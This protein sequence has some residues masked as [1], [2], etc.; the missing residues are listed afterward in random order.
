MRL[1]AGAMV[2]QRSYW[3]CEEKKR[4]PRWDRGTLQF[5]E[6]NTEQSLNQ[7]LITYGGLLPL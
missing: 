2:L 4:L 6:L 3:P 5:C 1:T 7:P